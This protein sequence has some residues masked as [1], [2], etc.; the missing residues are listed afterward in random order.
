MGHPV[1]FFLARKALSS[2]E[3][4][5]KYKGGADAAADLCYL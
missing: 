3:S 2:S 1:S 4:I 5:V